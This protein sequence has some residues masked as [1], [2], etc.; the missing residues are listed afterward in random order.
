MRTRP[1]YLAAIATGG[2]RL[3]VTGGAA[4][5]GIR[6]GAVQRLRTRNAARVVVQAARGLPVVPRHAGRLLPSS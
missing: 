4:A 2:L 5:A 6:A 1:S 3:L